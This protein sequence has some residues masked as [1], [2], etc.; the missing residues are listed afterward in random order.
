VVVLGSAGAYYELNT[1]KPTPQVTSAADVEVDLNALAASQEPAAP[2]SPH[3]VSRISRSNSSESAGGGEQ[4]PVALPARS[5]LPKVDPFR[6]V[7]GDWVRP[8][9]GPESSCFC[10]RWGVAHEGIDLAGPQGSPIVAAGDGVVLEAGPISGFG[11]WVVIE[12][13]N[14]DVSIYGHMYTVAVAAGDHV[15]AGQHLADI[16]SD[17]QST[18]PHLHFG[19]RLGGKDGPYIDPAPWLRARGV[20]VGTYNPS[21]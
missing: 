2:S 4:A 8:A 19:V 18:G 3:R 21:R 7:S 12:H 20:D 15:K 9:S 17:G 16:G 10:S 1:S 11:H 5:A 13:S 6:T 14:G